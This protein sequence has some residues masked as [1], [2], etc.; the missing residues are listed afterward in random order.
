[1]HILLYYAIFLTSSRPPP[2]A[3]SKTGFTISAR[4]LKRANSGKLGLER[5]LLPYDSMEASANPEDSS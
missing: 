2:E 3:T 5:P 4:D 1:M